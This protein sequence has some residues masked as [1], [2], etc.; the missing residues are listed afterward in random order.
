MRV[1]VVSNFYPP[2]HQGG[3]ELGCQDVVDGL[4][5]RGHDVRVLTS[6]TGV[7]RPTDEGH[8]LRRLRAVHWSDR[9]KLRHVRKLLSRE[10]RN[11]RVFLEVCA[12]F[13]PDVVQIWNLVDTSVS[14]PFLAQ[15][16]GLPV[17][18]YVFDEWLAAW[19]ADPWLLR[20][21]TLRTS[22]FAP[23]VRAG[24]K[25]LGLALPSG[26]LDLRGAQYASEFLRRA[27]R[28]AGREVEGTE[29]VPWGLDLES[30]ALRERPTAPR[31]LLYAGQ[32]VRH[33][34]VHTA[35][36]AL[37]RLVHEHGRDEL[38]LTLA[39]GTKDTAY[40]AEL[41]ALAAE[42]GLTDRVTF[43]G[44]LQRD[45]LLATYREH[46]ILLFT[47]C[48]NEPFGIVRLEA[49]AS[50]LPVVTTPTGAAAEIHDLDRTGLFFPAEDAAGCAREVLRL[51]E[52]SELFDTL[53]ARAR[54]A[55]EQ[56]FH[57]AR[58]LDSIERQLTRQRALSVAV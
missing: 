29:V 57:F 11:Q 39:G 41:E 18:Y 23:L 3:Y 52:S 48:W 58:T 45:A 47:S 19:D 27:A 56:R 24:A 46:D 55:V 37:G 49:M 42:L 1:L 50:G 12:E 21:A 33:K 16:A 20:R 31:R 8:I 7:G 25:A 28:E 26:E 14:I 32:L 13:E 22:V 10:R 17:A 5:A 15:A 40:R 43:L 51:L 6:D 53:R 36:E 38:T 4:L 54:T 9:L 2:H 30:Y 34:G 44:P 35:V